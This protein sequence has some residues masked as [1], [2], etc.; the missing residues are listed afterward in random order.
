MGVVIAVATPRQINCQ[1][2]N[3]KTKVIRRNN[4]DM[5]LSPLTEK[6]YARR[7]AKRVQKIVL[8]PLIITLTMLSII[9][10]GMVVDQW[11]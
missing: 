5:M 7:R 3:M 6:A 10:W 2:N 4:L 1:R 9:F 8:I 11:I